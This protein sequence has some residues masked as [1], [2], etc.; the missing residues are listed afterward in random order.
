MGLLE[1]LARSRATRMP[2]PFQNAEEEQHLPRC[3]SFGVIYS[4]GCGHFGCKV[5]RSRH[6][7]GILT[8]KAGCKAALP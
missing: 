3:P 6:S 2:T 5:L 7:V 4:M 8:G 1:T